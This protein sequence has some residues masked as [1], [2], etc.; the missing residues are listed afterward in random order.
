MILDGLADES[1]SIQNVTLST[2]HVFGKQYATTS[3]PI[4]LPTIQNNVFNDK[5]CICHSF[6]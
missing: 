5:W 6:E 1:E 2:G 4:L 3:L